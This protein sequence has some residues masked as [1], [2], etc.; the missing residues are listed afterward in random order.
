[1]D[2]TYLAAMVVMALVGLFITA[3]SGE[4]ALAPRSVRRPAARPAEAV[5]V[6]E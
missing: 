1:M 4:G 3:L 5:R 2:H 6:R